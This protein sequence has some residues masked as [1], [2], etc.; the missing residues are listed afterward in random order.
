[1][2]FIHCAFIKWYIW[3]KTTELSIQRQQIKNSGLDSKSSHWFRWKCDWNPICQQNLSRNKKSAN[4]NEKLF[5]TKIV[6][7]W[8]WQNKIEKFH[9]QKKK[10]WKV[11]WLQFFGQNLDV[12]INSLYSQCLKIREKVSFIIVSEAGYIYILSR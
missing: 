9:C 8:N 5:S 6:H 7:F 10:S 2:I 3:S 11:F 12:H 1:M 4:K